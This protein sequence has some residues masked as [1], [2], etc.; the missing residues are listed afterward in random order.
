MLDFA[1][2]LKIAKETG[3]VKKECWRN[4]YL[5]FYSY[6]ELHSGWYVEGWAIPDKKIP[7]NLEHGWI[8]RTDGSVVD[9]TYALLGHKDPQYFPAVRYTFTQVTKLAEDVFTGNKKAIH[10][11]LFDFKIT[12]RYNH[13]EYEEVYIAS[14]K[15]ALGK[16][17]FEKMQLWRKQRE[18]MHQSPKA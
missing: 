6:E 13:P 1:L 5:A 11:P 3:A 9:P 7:L 12:N 18:K 14:L 17:T 2:S 15:S 16:E 8:E 10:L 4:A